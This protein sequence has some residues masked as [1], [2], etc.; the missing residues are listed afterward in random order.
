MCEIRR[1]SKTRVKSNFFWDKM[2]EEMSKPLRFSFQITHCQWFVFFKF[3]KIFNSI[4]RVQKK[5]RK[6]RR[7]PKPETILFY[8]KIID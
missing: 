8:S 3:L 5:L 7:F 6:S 1:G 4:A 2:Q